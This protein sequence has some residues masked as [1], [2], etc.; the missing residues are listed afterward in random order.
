M[1]VIR[2]QLQPVKILRMVL[3]Q[4]KIPFL[5]ELLRSTMPVQNKTGI[6]QTAFLF[7]PA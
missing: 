7:F 5:K 1:V 3:G 6:Y 2:Y 4:K